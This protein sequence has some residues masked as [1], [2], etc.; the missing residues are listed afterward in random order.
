MDLTPTLSRVRISPAP[1]TL[2]GVVSIEPSHLSPFPYLFSTALCSRQASLGLLSSVL[3]TSIWSQDISP[4]I[5]HDGLS[6]QTFLPS[7]SLDVHGALL[8]N[9]QE[10]RT[11]LYSFTPR[12]ARIRNGQ[13]FPP[14]L[15]GIFSNVLF[16]E[17][18]SW[19]FWKTWLSTPSFWS[20]LIAEFSISL[21]RVMPPFLDFP[22]FSF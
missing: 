17:K 2:S 4:S 16:S 20:D 14:P 3:W 7:C 13:M 6:R 10:P 1:S 8:N 18:P 5:L 9:L 11:F 15:L 21:W 22:V 12:F 19:M